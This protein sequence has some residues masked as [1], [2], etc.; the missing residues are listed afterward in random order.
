[1][2]Y[3]VCVLMAIDAWD[4]RG[5]MTSS[6]MSIWFKERTVSQGEEGYSEAN[7][8]WVDQYDVSPI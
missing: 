8:A 4:R 5:K 7:S 6:A 2:S 1:M 3:S